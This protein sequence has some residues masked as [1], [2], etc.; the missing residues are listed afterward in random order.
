MKIF[1]QNMYSFV[2]ERKKKKKRWEERT[3][4]DATRSRGS[5]EEDGRRPPE[6]RHKERRAVHTLTRISCPSA[7]LKP[8]RLL[9]IIRFSTVRR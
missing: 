4:G 6:L 5:R 8:A 9:P 2:I 1:A 3:A 7:N